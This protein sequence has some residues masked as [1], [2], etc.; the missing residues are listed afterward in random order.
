MATSGV[1]VKLGVTGINDFKRDI[2]AAQLKIKTLKAAMDENEASFKAGGDAQVYF[3]QKTRLAK[4]QMTLQKSVIEKGEAALKAMKENGVDPSSAAFQT[5]QQKVINART[6]LITMNEKLKATEDQEKDTKTEAGKLA[7][8]VESIGKKQ[9]LDAIEEGLNKISSATKTAV[10][11]ATQLGKKLWGLGTDAAKWADNEITLSATYDIDVETLQRMQGAAEL[12]DVSVED[13]LKAKDNLNK[14]MG[15]GNETFETLGVAVKDSAGNTR[16]AMDV[17]WDV[18]EALNQMTDEANKETYAQQLLGKSWKELQPLFKTGR[19]KYEE[20]LADQE[21]VSEEDV[22]RLGE[23][24]DALN[25]LENSWNSLKRSALATMAPAMTE[26]AGAIKDFTSSDLAKNGIQTITD[27][28]KWLV[29]NKALVVG[30]ISAI[31]VELAALKVS[32]SVVSLMKTW[33]GVKG[34]FGNTATNTATNAATQTAANAAANAATNAGVNAATQTATKIGGVGTWL[35][36]P[37]AG[38]IGAQAIITGAIAAAYERNTNKNIRGSEGYMDLST[39]GDNSLKNA[40][41]EYVEAK[42]AVQDMIDNGTYSDEKANEL[43]DAVDS[44]EAALQGMEGWEELLAAYSAWRQ[45]GSLGNEDWQLPESWLESYFGDVSDS[46][47]DMKDAAGEISEAAAGIEGAAE[48]GVRKGIS[49][50][51]IT[52]DGRTVG[53]LVAPYVSEEIVAAMQ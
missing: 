16:D 14:A 11:K 35:Q 44:A 41:I 53:K 18:G 21:V 8:A 23:F 28:L 4:Q 32:E 17:F 45:E 37:I 39:G 25:E 1:D 20:T 3:E 5:M 10:N 36:S 19:T 22:K 50:V 40:F 15:K 34:F 29:E 52:L 9:N 31:G 46:G 43:M 2:N 33:N 7:T 49:G 30:A 27:G 47:K 26:L 13:M 6:T 51:K 12:V 24:D 38:L 42:K 48:S